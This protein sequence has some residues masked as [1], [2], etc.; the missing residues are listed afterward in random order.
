MSEAVIKKTMFK[1]ELSLFLV[2]GDEWT[3]LYKQRN[4][5]V[6]QAADI[7]ALAVTGRRRVDGMYVCFE[8][9]D[10]QKY[11]PNTDND[12]EYY[13]P[14]PA[15]PDRSFVRVATLGDPV[16]SSTDPALAGNKVAFLG[17]T[18]GSSELPGVPFLDSVSSIYHTALVSLDP[19]GQQ[20]RDLIFSCADLDTPIL[21][22]AGAQLGV[23]WE[24]TYNTA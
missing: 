13:N 24:I 16:I 8:N 1:G 20:S 21:K 11:I 19:D 10:V 23:R 5:I 22:I 15:V 17:V 14:T 3:P 18:D 6:D 2:R 7:M 12:A 4:M 9:S